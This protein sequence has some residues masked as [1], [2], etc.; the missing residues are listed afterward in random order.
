METII[1]EKIGVAALME[2]FSDDETARNIINAQVVEIE[3]VAHW[4]DDEHGI[5]TIE[6]VEKE[7]R[8]AENLKD[9]V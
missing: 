3:G 7:A 4:Y 8:E 9:E 2:Y 5:A 1:N 6:T